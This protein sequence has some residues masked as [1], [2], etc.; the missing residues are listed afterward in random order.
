MH[1]D[2]SHELWEQTFIRGEIRTAALIAEL[3]GRSHA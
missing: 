2:S 1:T 3:V